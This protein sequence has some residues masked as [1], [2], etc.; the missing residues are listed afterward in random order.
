M[1]SLTALRE[2][3]P[4]QVSGSVS[5]VVGH[6]IEIRG[7]RLRIGDALTVEASTGPLAAEVVA[8]TPE[9]ARALVLGD[10]GGIGK[11]DRVNLAPS[12]A[13]A[14]VGQ[15]MLGRV[16]DAMGRP[17]DG[18]PM[19]SGD[20][21]R[22]DAVAP[23]A[24]ERSRVTEPLPVGVRAL[25]TF[26]TA[27]RGQRLGIFAGSGVGKSTLLGMMARGTT[28]DVNVVALIGER[29]REVRDFIED[30]LGP[31]AMAR[32]VCVVATSDQAPL[33]RLRAGFLATTIAE[34]FADRGGNV[35][36]M[37]DSL[38]RLA[39]AQREVGLA[40]G[41]P[42]TARGYTPSVFS[43][44]PRLLERAGPR[45]NGS[46]TAFYTVLV[47][48]DDLNEPVADTARSILDGHIVLD[49]RLAIAGRYP[50][51]DPLGSL[52]R[53]AAK[54]TDPERQRVLHRV[55]GAMAAAEEVRDLV[56]VGAYVA[57]TNPMADAGLALMPEV[58]AFLSQSMGEVSDYDAAWSRLAQLA[59]SVVTA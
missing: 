37:L 33:I 57:G 54:V 53:L 8:L 18:L 21:V 12:G 20:R 5:R 31:Q 28:A 14:V 27:G 22:L 40:A 24:L 4:W 43:M 1:P 26:V 16:V 19:W 35:L 15:D 41:E 55:R 46:I 39:M 29:G 13:G 32:T 11:S 34:W 59:N 58:I 6:E 56:E 36:L 25:D 52:S 48:G 2:V 50:A 47:E 3:R 51:V 17:L 44:L 10:L 38:T 23:P 42:P 9:G 45:A 30:D 49:R 7:L